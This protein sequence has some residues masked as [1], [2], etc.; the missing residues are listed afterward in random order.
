MPFLRSLQALRLGN[1][2]LHVIEEVEPEV[3]KAIEAVVPADGHKPILREAWPAIRA[4]MDDAIDKT[5]IGEI[6][7]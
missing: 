4:A 7:I 1:T 2:I 6:K 5:P 3:A